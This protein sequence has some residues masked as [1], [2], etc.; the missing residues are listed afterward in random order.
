MVCSSEHISSSRFQS[1]TN[2]SFSSVK[3]HTALFPPRS[4][5]KNMPRKPT[6]SIV[7][8]PRMTR[9]LEWESTIRNNNARNSTNDTSK[10]RKKIHIKYENAKNV[11]TDEKKIRDA[12]DKLDKKIRSGKTF[13]IR[14]NAD[15]SFDHT[16]KK[17]LDVSPF[18]YIF[19]TD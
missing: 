13:A 10:S 8:I 11:F 4:D 2:K 16:H 14:K 7:K 19:P 5:K 3:I 6:N 17:K 12:L 1:W 9:I 18:L 15:L